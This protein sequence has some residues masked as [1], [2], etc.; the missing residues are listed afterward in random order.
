MLY[1]TII[2]YTSV[3]ILLL[4]AMPF[5][6]ALAFA[7]DSA[8]DIINNPVVTLEAI[9]RTY[10]VVSPVIGV[11]K[12][13]SDIIGGGAPTPVNPVED[14][15]FDPVEL[16]LLFSSAVLLA[17]PFNSKCVVQFVADIYEPVQLHRSSVVSYTP[18]FLHISLSHR[19]PSKP[20]VQRQIPGAI[21]FAKSL[22]FCSTP[23]KQKA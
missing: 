8:A 3:A 5:V 9:V 12:V 11:G 18:P 14:V 2:Y 6:I 13:D 16:L 17:V 23:C 20:G 1:L 19:T 22:T 15:V 21:E 10:L 7:A 4:G